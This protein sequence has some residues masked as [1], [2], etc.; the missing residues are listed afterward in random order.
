MKE[1]LFNLRIRTNLEKIYV[2]TYR[3]NLGLGFRNWRYVLLEKHVQI[4]TEEEKMQMK[5]FEGL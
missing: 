1:E 4:W 5:R 3:F 2:K